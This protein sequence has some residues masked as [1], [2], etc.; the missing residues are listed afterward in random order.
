MRGFVLAVLL[1]CGLPAQASP[2]L[3]IG[4]GPEPETLDPQR[5]EGV[6]AGNVLRDLFEGLTAIGA[7]GRPRPAAASGWTISADGRLYTFRL[8][9]H[10]RWSNGDALTADDFVTGL[11]RAVTP[12]TGAPSAQLLRPIRHAAAIADGRLPP[13]QLAVRALDAQTLQIELEA[14][15]T[16]LLG[17][18]AQPLAFPVHAPS[19]RRHG[20]GFARPGRLV[21]NGAYRLE[22]WV[23]QSH[24]DLVR[25]P[26]YWNAARTAIERVRYLTTED[27]HSE[28]KR[29]R[30]G[31]LDI[32]YEIPPGQAERIRRELPGQLR[33]APY[34]GVYFYGLNLTRAPFRGRP[35][36]RQ[37]LSMVI[38]R[39]LIATRVLGGLALPAHGWV[40]PGT[41][42]HEPQRPAWA[43]W[44]YERRVAEA[45]ALYHAA[46]YTQAAPL[47]VEIRYNTHESHRRVATVIAAMWKQTLGVRAH[48]HN[49]EFKVFLYNRRLRRD[50]QVFRAAWMADFNDPLSF[51]GILHSAHGKNDS[52]WSDPS[53]DTL[54]ERASAMVD[55]GQRAPLLAQAEAKILAEVPVIPIYFYVS[56]HLVSPRVRGWTDNVLD[57]H[58]SKDLSLH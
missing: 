55:P 23:V 25:N 52:G 20:D 36:L 6:S 9:D 38:D 48:L 54:L 31:E 5:A 10:A 24:I 32:T 7:D 18:L 14:P 47:D 35:Q 39:E 28:Y 1:A 3:R 12:A 41:A 57:Y 2:P 37:A 50:T 34:L 19:L 11:R 51:L 40:P 8:R 33:V 44:P 43:D 56:K 13:E 15:A 58:Y 16:Y 27:L 22:D 49:E 42:G 45:R 21:G 17:V 4:N 46:G 26:H 29:Y 53:Y 30:A